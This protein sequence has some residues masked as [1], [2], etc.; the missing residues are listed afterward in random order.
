MITYIGLQ[1]DCPCPCMPGETAGFIGALAV[2]AVVYAHIVA[3]VG[4]RDRD[5]LADSMAG[6]GHQRCFSLHR[7]STPFCK[8][9]HTLLGG[10]YVYVNVLYHKFGII[11]V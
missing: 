5:G 9:W 6:A 11:Q 4:Q 1:R 3:V 2:V 8:F 10:R 7:L